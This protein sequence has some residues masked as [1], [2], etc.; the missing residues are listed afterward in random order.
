MKYFLLSFRKNDNRLKMGPTR[1]RK[2]KSQ[3]DPDL[4][5]NWTI[6]Q[7]KE[8]LRN[9]GIRFPINARRMALVWLLKNFETTN[10]SHF[11]NVNG[12]QSQSSILG[13]R[14]Q[15]QFKPYDVDSYAHVNSS[16]LSSVWTHDSAGAGG[17]ANAREDN[18]ENGSARSH[19]AANVNN[20]GGDHS[21]RVLIG[22]VS[23]L[24]FIIQGNYF[25][26]IQ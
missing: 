8:E 20:Y 4:Y 16:L 11:N 18:A 7:L 5:E 21:N 6:V 9:R 13:D 17:I 14:A 3:Y 1:R 15:Q 24:A 22:L 2:S 12:Q 19:D 26:P 25:P 10:D 23:N